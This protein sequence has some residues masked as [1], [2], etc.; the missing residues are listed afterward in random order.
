MA[1]RIITGLILAPLIVVGAWFAPATV[2]VGMAILATF[3]AAYE[4]LSMFSVKE[5]RV[6]FWGG[7]AW[8]TLA[9]CLARFGGQYLLAYIFCTP[10][11]AMSLF[12]LVPE[13]I[14]QAAREIPA[15]GF[16]ASYVG[17]LMAC[18][19][20][21]AMLPRGN[22]AL[23][24]LFAVVFLGDTGAY[25]GGKFLGKRKLYA[26][27]S[28]KKTLVGSLFGLLGSIGGAFLVDATFGTPLS[29][30]QLLLV[31]AAGAVT[32]QIGDLCESILKRSTGIK[33]SGTLLPGHGGM[34]DRVDG[35]LFAA[36]VVYGV[37]IMS[38]VGG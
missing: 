36:P 8:I 32:E 25:F 31:G 22:S 30:G 4:F 33:D 16:G 38:S 6:T 20:M 15:V 27:V 23:L 26:R 1:K 12:L 5:N 29:T 37:F 10:L 24:V 7:V 9:P 28:P 35:L 34:L 3:A 14:P 18:V 19:V 11:F 17:L 13:R 21:L 2:G